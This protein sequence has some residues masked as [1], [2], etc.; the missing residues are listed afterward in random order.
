MNYILL[1][2]TQLDGIVIKTTVTTLSKTEGSQGVD[3]AHS[4]AEF[5]DDIYS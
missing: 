3:T 1:L 2:K 4:N 5:A